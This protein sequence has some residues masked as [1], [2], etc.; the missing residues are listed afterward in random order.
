MTSIHQ[1]EYSKLNVSVNYHCTGV[2]P[3]TR[4]DNYSTQGIT[5]LVDTTSCH[6]NSTPIYYTSISGNGLHDGTT[7]VRAL[8][9]PVRFGFSVYLRN[10]RAW[11]VLQMLNYSRIY[12]WNVNWVGLERWKT[13]TVSLSVVF[14]LSLF[15]SA[16]DFWCHKNV[17]SILLFPILLFARL[18]RNSIF[19]ITQLNCQSMSRITAATEDS[20]API[21]QVRRKAPASKSMLNADSFHIKKKF[22]WLAML[23]LLLFIVLAFV[24]PLLIVFVVTPKLCKWVITQSDVAISLQS[25]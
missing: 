22:F 13:A 8:Y 1:S 24:L 16:K 18:V 14:F 11:G 25:F 10:S 15:F 12:Q 4:W 6:F 17:T 9:N 5:M 21:M 2:S 3:W 20:R 19:V 23:G 7:S